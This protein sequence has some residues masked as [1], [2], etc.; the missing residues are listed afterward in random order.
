MKKV[1]FCYVISI[2]AITTSLVAFGETRPGDRPPGVSPPPELSLKEAFAGS[3]LVGAAL[4]K[5]QIL[6][7]EPG[8]LEFVSSQFNALTPENDMKWERIQPLENQFDWEAPDALVQ[9]SQANNIHLTGHVLVWHSQTPDWVFEDGAGKPASRELLLARME[10]HISTV[11]G[12]YKG[13]VQS[14]DVVNEALNEDGS[15]RESP[16][17]TIIGEDYLE[18]AFEFAHRADPDAELYYNDYNLFV[19]AKRDGAVHL[20]QNLQDKRVVVHGIGMQAHYGLDNPKDLGQFED[21][22]EAYAELGVSVLV[23]ELDISVLPF[24]EQEKWGADISLNMELQEQFN[25]YAAGLPPAVAQAQSDRFVDLFRILLNHRDSVS[26]VTFWGVD[27]VHSWRNNWPMQGRTDYPLLFDR[28][29]RPRQAFYEI[30]KL[31]TPAQQGAIE[32]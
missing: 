11:V 18:K 24:P 2:I 4:S 12:R 9:F 26:R 16:W 28:N 6:G 10:S 29:R 19:P 20:V 13:K 7:A 22:I 32:Q 31:T 30:I 21:A 3:F 5:E 23:T 15:L 1:L 17:L 25:P 27:N 14:W 8:T